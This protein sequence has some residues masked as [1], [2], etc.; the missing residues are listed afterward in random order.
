MRPVQA[1]GR[2]VSI[3]SSPAAHPPAAS[4]YRCRAVLDIADHAAEIAIADRSAYRCADDRAPDQRFE[5]GRPQAGI[6]TA[7]TIHDER[8]IDLSSSAIVT[9]PRST[10]TPSRRRSRVRAVLEQRRRVIKLRRLAPARHLVGAPR[11]PTRWR[12]SF[13]G[14]RPRHRHERSG[15]RGCARAR[16]TPVRSCRTAGRTA[17]ERDPLQYSRD[18]SG[19][20]YPTRRFLGSYDGPLDSMSMSS[21]SPGSRCSSRALHHV[22]ITSPA[23]ASRSAPASRSRSQR[24]RCARSRSRIRGSIR[25]LSSVTADNPVSNAPFMFRH[26]AP[27]VTG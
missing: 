15:R 13:G 21:C 27:R 12:G 18:R 19:S 23:T 9:I 14:R 24:C 22:S 25:Q 26:A 5:P 16:P 2:R 3:E 6:V 8:A 17:S 4:A 11:S 20:R 10:G 7:R 1:Y